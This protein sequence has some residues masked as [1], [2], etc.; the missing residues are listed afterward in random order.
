MI[1]IDAT[2]INRGGGK[3][4]LNYFISTLKKKN[5]L[6]NYIFILD[7]RL[8]SKNFQNDIKNEKKYY[9][10]SNELNRYFIFRKIFKNENI[11]TI[12][13]FNNIPPNFTKENIKTFV[14]FHNT[15]LLKKIDLKY[16]YNDFIIFLKRTY[17]KNLNKSSYV[18]IV[19]TNLVK[20]KLNTIISKFSNEILTLPFFEDVR[21]E[22]KLF[23]PTKISFVYIADASKHKNHIFLLDTWIN[24]YKI[25]NLK[26]TLYFT[27]NENQSLFLQNKINNLNK[28]GL[29]IKNLGILNKIDLLELYKNTSFLIYPSLEESFGLPLIEATQLN[30]FVIAIDLPY[31]TEIIEPSFL[32]S[33]Y[34]IQDLIQILYEI[35]TNKNLKYKPS[36]LKINN[37]IN[38]IINLL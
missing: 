28:L 8:E 15:I 33:H 35:I 4:L 13:C 16:I 36:K 30:K 19:Q 7:K 32:F 23:T 26:P 24:L 3:N 38:N 6:D 9:I 5:I 34:N 22:N 17:I 25:Y 12:F 18:W 29:D 14:L 10:K 2:Y 1:L 21:T 31:V 27:F 20:N 37:N 11:K